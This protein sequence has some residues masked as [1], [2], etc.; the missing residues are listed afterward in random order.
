[1]DSSGPTV[2]GQHEEIDLARASG[3]EARLVINVGRMLGLSF[4]DQE[5]AAFQKFSNLEAEENG[6][7]AK[8]D[9]GSCQNSKEGGSEGG[10]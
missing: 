8:V 1:M 2:E 5:S 4:G 6:G 10:R 9:L 7:L 3:Q